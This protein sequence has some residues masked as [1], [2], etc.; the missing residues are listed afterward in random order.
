MAVG[1]LAAGG[2]LLI[3]NRTEDHLVEITLTTISAYGS[4][5][6]AEY[7]HMSGVLASLAAG[8]VIGNIGHTGAASKSGRAH[9]LAFWEYA[10]FLANSIVFILIGGHEAQEL[11]RL[12]TWGA[13]VAIGL[14]LLGRVAAVYPI[15]A[16]FARSALRVAARHQHVLV[17]GGLRGALALALALALAIPNSCPTRVQLYWL[18]SPSWPSR[19]SCKA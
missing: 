9:V 2:L 16:L 15:C 11:T 18:H 12:F 10:A 17:W 19:S 7:F 5:M 1:A 13:A 8:L 6:T 3:A 4:F 14:V